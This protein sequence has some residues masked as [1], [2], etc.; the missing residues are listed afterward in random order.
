[1]ISG[2]MMHLSKNMHV[3]YVYADQSILVQNSHPFEKQA[4]SE[5]CMLLRM[6]PLF[7]LHAPSHM[8]MRPCPMRYV[9]KP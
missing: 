1:M 2:R 5:T 9:I 4:S 8:Y 6:N 3:W 7:L